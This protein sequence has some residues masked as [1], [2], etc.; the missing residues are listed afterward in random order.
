LARFAAILLQIAFVFV[1]IFAV[2]GQIFPVM[3]VS[4]LSCAS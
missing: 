1:H 4:L 2:G 3:C